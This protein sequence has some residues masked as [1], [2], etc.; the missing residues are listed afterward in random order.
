MK[1]VRVPKV[2][3]VVAAVVATVVVVEAVASA[4]EIL[5]ARTASI[6]RI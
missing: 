5:T 6:N 4:E 2:A 1:R 3:H